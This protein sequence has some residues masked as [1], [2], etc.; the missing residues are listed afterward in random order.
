M[1]RTAIFA[2]YASD[3]IINH[4]IV[5]YLMNLKKIASNIVFISDNS[6]S[7][8]EIR[9]IE[10]LCSHYECEH[11]GEYD[12]G[13]YKRGFQYLK[14]NQMINEIDELIVCNDSC[15]CV[16]DFNYVFNEMASRNCDF[17]SMTGSTQFQS[18]MQSYF[19]VFKSKVFLS[20]VF[21][22]YI[23]KVKHL[24]NY[25]DI[26]HIYELP[27]KAT[28]EQY[29]FKGD[30]FIAPLDNDRNANFYPIYLMEN[31]CPLVK[32][33]NFTSIRFATDSIFSV[34][35]YLLKKHNKASLDVLDLLR[36]KSKYEFYLYEISL[37]V[38][39]FICRVDESRSGGRRYRICMIPVWYSH[40]HRR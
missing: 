18:H 15:L 23:S 22:D 37:R 26:V 3:G 8:D 39:R 40:K 29:N 4:Y 1:N 16:D 13:S 30:S 7:A 11:H 25:D 35:N 34:Y 36:L 38:K 19:L 28:L 6:F 14:K 5:T 24:D 31:H 17:W 9:K 33:K 20:D 2:C 12:F 21:N 27:L 32:K 10:S